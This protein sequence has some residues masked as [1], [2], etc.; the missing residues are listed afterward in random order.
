MACSTYY[1]YS[2]NAAVRFLIPISICIESFR[3]PQILSKAAGYSDMRPQST[4][5]QSA[6]M[7]LPQLILIGY[8]FASI[9]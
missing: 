7:D 9:D 5:Q 8:Q 3:S 6:V 2:T 4:W 1:T